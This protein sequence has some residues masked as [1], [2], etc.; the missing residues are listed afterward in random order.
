[1]KPADDCDP[2]QFIR[3]AFDWRKVAETANQA[4][5]DLQFYKAKLSLYLYYRCLRWIS[6]SLSFL[7][8][9]TALRLDDGMRESSS[10]LVVHTEVCTCCHP[11]HSCVAQHQSPTRG[12]KTF[13]RSNVVQGVARYFGGRRSRHEH[14]HGRMCRTA[15]C[16]W[17]QQ[18]PAFPAE[19]GHGA[20]DVT[21]A[22]LE[23]SFFA[24]YQQ[25]GT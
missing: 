18:L 3:M 23:P 6:A 21:H 9:A 5:L 10:A 22:P 8:A 2:V 16:D 1:M 25:R 24:L 11:Y 19:C 7:H 17:Q 4:K 20:G 15:A 12:T 13:S 14:H